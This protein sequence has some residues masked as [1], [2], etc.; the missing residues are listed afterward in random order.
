[1]KKP[2]R[3]KPLEFLAQ[4]QKN[5]KLSDRVFAAVERGGKVTADEVL[6]IAKEFGFSFTRNEFE[7]EV[8]RDLARRFAAGDQSLI[9]MA[10]PKPKPKPPKPPLSSCA[11]GCLSYTISWHPSAD[12]RL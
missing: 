10:K 3:S 2:K 8:K 4:A 12:P 1:M 6:E 11:R 5:R 7:R 9:A